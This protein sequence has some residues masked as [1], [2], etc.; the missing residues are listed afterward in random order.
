MVFITGSVHHGLTTR[1]ATEVENDPCVMIK[2]TSVPIGTTSGTVA[3]IRYM[4]I[5]PATKPAN[6][7]FKVA[8]P[9][10]TVGGVVTDAGGL[11]GAASPKAG[12]GEVGP[13]PVR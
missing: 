5:C 9:S 1:T 2:G 12:S 11:A 6:V 7:T 13:S 10:M 8:A 4:P 3:S